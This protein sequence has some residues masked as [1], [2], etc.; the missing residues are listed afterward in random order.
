VLF[1]GEVPLLGYLAALRRLLAG[2]GG[3]GGGGGGGGS[4]GSEGG[5]LSPPPLL[6]HF[7]DEPPELRGGL[8][9][10]AFGAEEDWEVSQMLVDGEEGWEG[11][12]YFR[13]TVVRRLAR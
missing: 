3:D 8:L 12:D 10:A 6:V 4:G 1:C 13:Y 11:W 2:D 5:G 7:S 9:R